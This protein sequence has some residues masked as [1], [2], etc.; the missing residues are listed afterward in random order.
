MTQPMLGV[1]LKRCVTVL[2]SSNLSCERQT[3]YENQSLRHI[4][5]A[6]RIVRRMPSQ[7]TDT[8]DKLNMKVIRTGTFFC[9]ITTAVSLPRTAMAVWPEPEIAL[10]AY[11]EESKM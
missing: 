11:S 4:G 2:A 5:D 1:M 7:T 3:R 10:N 8:V 9:V 6:R